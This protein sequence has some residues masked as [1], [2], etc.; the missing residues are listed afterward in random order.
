MNM[1]SGETAAQIDAPTLS[2]VESYAYLS[3]I[4]VPSYGSSLSTY[5][6]IQYWDALLPYEGH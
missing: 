3:L 5:N 2:P 6:T 1:D 4:H